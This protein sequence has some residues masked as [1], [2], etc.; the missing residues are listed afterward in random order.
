[1]DSFLDSQSKQSDCPSKCQHLRFFQ[2]EGRRVR[3]QGS[4]LGLGLSIVRQLVELH[5]G[6]V[7]VASPNEHH[8]ATFVVRLPLHH[9][10]ATA[11]RTRG[12]ELRDEDLR[13]LRVL[14]VEDDEETRTAIVAALRVQGIEVS[15]VGSAGQALEA[16]RASRPQVV[17]S[18][19]GLPDLD[20]HSLM[21]RL[22]ELEQ[23]GEATPVPSIALT[24]YAQESDRARALESGFDQ[25]LPKPVEPEQLVSL[26]RAIAARG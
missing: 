1:M 13:G 12:P 25:F 16:F 2:K 11:E 19:I 3:A 6:S 24:A 5:A 14:L 9:E 26:V 7:G 23:E 8:G 15:A 21:R 20:G 18:D 10:V 17:L 22:R 4:G